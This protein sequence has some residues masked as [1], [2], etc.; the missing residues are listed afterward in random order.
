MDYLRTQAP[1]TAPTPFLMPHHILRLQRHLPLDLSEMLASPCRLLSSAQEEVDRVNTLTPDRQVVLHMSPS[2]QVTVAEMDRSFIPFNKY[3]GLQ[4]LL[5]PM[6]THSYRS[7]TQQARATI[8]L[9]SPKTTTMASRKTFIVPE[10]IHFLHLFPSRAG[11][12]LS[13]SAPA[14]Y[15]I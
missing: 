14:H 10:L 7:I 5:C 12:R 4:P 11:H 13:A 8:L 9:Q 15:R 1:T 3:P 6:P 2:R